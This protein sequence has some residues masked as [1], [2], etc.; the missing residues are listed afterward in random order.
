[1]K[2]TA[3]CMWCQISSLPD[4][5]INFNSLSYLWIFNNNLTN[6]PSTFCN[7]NINWNSDDSSFLPYF[8]SGGNQLCENLPTCIESSPNFDSSIDPLYYSFEITLEQECDET[9]STMDINN[10]GIINVIDI[11][12]V[13]NIILGNLNPNENESCAA[14]INSDSIINVIDIVAIVNYILN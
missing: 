9:C 8:G 12:A 14:D 10:D 1:M 7:L 2:A 5:F 3:S 11:V 13:V 6:L 4:S